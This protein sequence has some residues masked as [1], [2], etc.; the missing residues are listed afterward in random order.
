[1][2]SC[3]PRSAATAERVARRDKTQ[4]KSAK[5]ERRYPPAVV[6][7]LAVLAGLDPGLVDAALAAVD[8]LAFGRQRGKLLG[9]RHVTGDLTGL[10]RLRFDVPGTHPARF[11]IV[12]RLL[13]HDTR[14]RGPGHRRTSRSR[15]AVDQPASCIDGG[16]GRAKAEPVRHSVHSPGPPMSAV[17]PATAHGS[18]TG[19]GF[20]T[21]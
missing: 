11:R 1:M 7:D 14:D 10:A 21:G 6:D 2:S 18:V 16:H 20:C 9:E 17:R 13:Q 19:A 4:P 12:Y 3:S 5:V 15:R 8:D